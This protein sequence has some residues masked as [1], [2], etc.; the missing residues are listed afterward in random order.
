MD[1]HTMREAVKIIGNGCTYRTICYYRDSY[2][3][4]KDVRHE[5][6]YWFVN[7]N[8][9]AKVK[10]NQAKNKRTITDSRTK[11]Q[12]LEEI[13]ILTNK[14]QDL[15][16]SNGF[17][18]DQENERIELFTND[19][20]QL[21]SERLIEWRI[22]KKEIELK[23]EQFLELK[24][25]KS[26]LKIRNEYLEKSNNNILEQHAKLIEAIGQRNRIEAVEKGVIPR[27]I[28]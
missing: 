20:Y 17:E 10:S 13:K 28:D 23:A 8:F 7:D 3:D 1:W 16:E 2:I 5:G 26:Y 27:N 9:I 4:G 11:V 21:F 18:Y 12:L 24:E 6:V 25:D 14:I 19:E 15:E 22:Q